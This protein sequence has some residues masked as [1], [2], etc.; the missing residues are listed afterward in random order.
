MS[1]VLQGPQQEV[2]LRKASEVAPGL[3]GRRLWIKWPY[4]QEAA[5]TAVSD[6]DM[7]VHPPFPALS[8][9]PSVFC[10]C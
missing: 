7:E 1:A 8:L 3:L 2:A 4:L 9:L 10:W 5:V 6:V